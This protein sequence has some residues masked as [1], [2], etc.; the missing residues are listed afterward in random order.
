MTFEEFYKETTGRDFVK[1]TGN[2]KINS[3]PTRV[4][5][6]ELFDKDEE[7]TKTKLKKKDL[8]SYRNKNIIREYM[9]RNKGVDYE[10]ADD[11]KL[12][13]DFMD[14][15]RWFNT[16]TVSTA[17]EVM[18]VSKGDD[19]DKKAAKEAYDLYDSLESMWTNDGFYGAVDGVKDYV[20]AAV[21]DPTNYIG[22]LTGGVGKY[23]AMG[24]SA[25]SKAAIK[26][27]ADKA[28][29]K[30]MLNGATK[31][32]AKKAGTEA[33]EAM[34]KKMVT[35]GANSKV[36]SE[37]VNAAAI[38]ARREVLAEAGAKAKKDVLKQRER[39]GGIYGLLGTTSADAIVAMVQ[40][41]AIQD[42]YLEVGAQ[43]KY[44]RTQ[45]LLS[46]LLGGVGGA[47]HLTGQAMKGTSKL[48]EAMDT[49]DVKRFVEDH[50][51]KKAL[52]KIAEL[53]ADL[54]KVADEFGED[55]VEYKD[56]LARIGVAKSKTMDTP[57]LDSEAQKEATKIIKEN[58]TKW[59]DKVERGGKK[60]E[61]LAVPER[62]LKT[63]MLG[64]NPDE[65]GGLVKV[66]K[67]NGI[68]PKRNT[69]VSDIMTN[70]I[71]Y[72]PQDDLQDLS[73]SLKEVIHIDLSDTA[74]LGMTIGDVLA[75]D[76]SRAG[77]TLSVMSQVRRALHG[78]VVAGN[79][80]FVNDVAQAEARDLMGKE[81]AEA[82]K[83]RPFAYGQSI[84]KRL[85]VS[86]PATTMANVQGFATYNILQSVA[87]MVSFGTYSILAGAK[88][89]TNPEEAAEM[90]K[91]AHVYRA[92]Q[93]QKMRNF[94]DAKTTHDVYMRYLDENKDAKKLLF[95]TVGNAAEAS[96]KRYNMSENNKF[97]YGMFGIENLTNAASTM[98]G[99]RIQDTFTKSQM[100]MTEMDK[101]LRLKHE[102]T[103][104]D[105]LKS[106]DMGLIDDDVVGAAI[107][108][109]MRSVFSKD[110]TTKDQ[111]L[112]GAAQVVEKISNTP[113]FGLFLPFG[114]FMNN[115][116]ATTYQWSPLALVDSMRA[117]YKTEKRN[118]S[119][120]EAM[121]RG[122]VGTGALG[123]AMQFS[124]EQE[125][126]GLDYNIV[127]GVGGT[128][129][130]V[131]NAFPFSSFLATGRYFNRLW[132]GEATQENFT[133]MM[134]QLAIGQV[135]R[136]VQ[137]A[138]DLRNI[139]DYMSR[140]FGAESDGSFLP[141]P[142][143]DTLEALFKA[144]GNIAAGVTRPLD[145]V[146]KAT[147]FVFG[148]DYSKDIRQAE[149]GQIFTQAATR[150]FD[151]ILAALSDEVET[152]KGEQLRVASREGEVYDPNPLAKIFGLT[153]K[154]GRT[155]TE[156]AYSMA[157]MKS[158]TQDMRTKIPE[159]DK[160]F[161]TAI[162]PVLE[163]RMN[164][165]IKN[166][167]FLEADIGERRKLIKEFV[168]NPTR[169][170]IRN[171]L[172]STSGTKYFER[173][174]YKA[175]QKG[176]KFLRQK[177]MEMMKERGVDVNEVR[178]F[179]SMRELM[180]FNSFI[181]HLETKY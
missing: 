153:I 133:D 63:I 128:Q 12:V 120:V 121:S 81:A 13:E 5:G 56:I 66:L 19:L 111:T 50:P 26:A 40:A 42:L 27:A 18:F 166:K 157:E 147:G 44:S 92:I 94:M 77:S 57:L 54:A 145:F 2:S 178:D 41:D 36:A 96:S 177:A 164:K 131:K 137:F 90:M 129:I 78:G 134:E 95:E 82:G 167:R 61:N 154:Q 31:E 38:R 141:N 140:G 127:E 51:H 123:L 48:G 136:D 91:K 144:S 39:I 59:V 150:Y 161:N 139:G 115:V 46:G 28:A 49:F 8:Y 106:N 43:E 3:T 165:L 29:K 180:M 83:S 108:S 84:W 75:A 162:A 30:A 62:L 15:M 85:L 104:V 149:G 79:D 97:L 14:H 146:N 24:V 117:I 118:I 119:N 110:Y 47:F 34:T 55:S 23:A 9:T 35:Y 87:D 1:S 174:K 73:K 168:L 152:V 169:K 60:L 116:I 89:L 143:N 33:A 181:D 70:V 37:A 88:S 101:Y 130:D 64:D 160:V 20:F 132:K 45:T 52:N 67:D 80:R 11:E 156:K 148:T 172:D 125:K 17:G 126:K 107:D 7:A 21:T 113:G 74:D 71:R 68:H 102:R 158:W 103:L 173:Q 179:T 176:D 105:V 72:M 112:R 109:T 65:I 25:K 86:S 163:T 58:F 100:F 4:G 155:A 99:V 53:E 10:D 124:E 69:L 76:I 114:R 170:L 171:H 142:K 6:E 138:N 151:N 32:A 159:Y 135:A 16:N 122:I 22:A 175:S 98:T 93:G